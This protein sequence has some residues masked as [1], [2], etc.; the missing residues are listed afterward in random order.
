MKKHSLAILAMALPAFVTGSSLHAQGGAQPAGTQPVATAGTS[1]SGSSAPIGSSVSAPAQQPL[2]T[3]GVD[4]SDPFAELHEVAN[5]FRMA[6]EKI[7]A[8]NMAQIDTLLRTKKCQNLRVGGLLDRVVE[9]LNQ[10]NDAEVKYWKVW[11]DAEALRVED[12]QK[13]LAGMVVDEKR[14]ED[15]LVSVQKDRD[16]LLRDKATLEK[17]PTR[18]EDIRKRIDALVL[19]IRDSENRLTDAQKNFDDITIKV[20][21]IQV[22]INARLIEIRQNQRRV[23]AYGLEMK[24][25]YEKTRAAANEICNAAPPATTGN[26]KALPQRKGASAPQ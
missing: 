18:T 19:D 10:W 26:P 20:K 16:N 7:D 5:R 9:A 6:Y 21:N 22:S 14:A 2:P 25:D 8:D 3:G 17:Y 12:Q 13:S 1:P 15:M 11:G 23:E 4:S 24:S